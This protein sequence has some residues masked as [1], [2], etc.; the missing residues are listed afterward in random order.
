MLG[1]PRLGGGCSINPML[2]APQ[3]ILRILL[4]LMA[5]ALSRASMFL[6]NQRRR[7]HR[8]LLFPRRNRF[9]VVC[10]DVPG[11]IRSHVRLQEVIGHLPAGSVTRFR[12]EFDGFMEPLVDEDLSVVLVRADF[13]ALG[14]LGAA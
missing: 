9:L 3:T 11:N 6:D 12:R 10:S 7:H 2:Q 4:P 1:I 14:V 5:G 8:Q 13:A